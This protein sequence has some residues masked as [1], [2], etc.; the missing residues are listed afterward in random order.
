[1][2]DL[3]VQKGSPIKLAKGR[4]MNV[5]NAAKASP[6]AGKQGRKLPPE[7]GHIPAKSKEPPKDEILNDD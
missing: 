1:M 7:P 5:Q 2:S 3:K 6:D 4:S